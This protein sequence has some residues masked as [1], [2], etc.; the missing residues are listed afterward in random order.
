MG[1]VAHLCR[2]GAFGYVRTG[3]WGGLAPRPRFGQRW[4]MRGYEHP[5]LLLVHLQ[6]LLEAFLGGELNAVAEVEP[7]GVNG[8]GEPVGLFGGI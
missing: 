4:F 3:F 7:H 8:A 5:G 2:Y 6:E 1:E